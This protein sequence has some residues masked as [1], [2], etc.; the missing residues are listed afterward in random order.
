M[1]Q[2]I[3]DSVHIFSYKNRTESYEQDCFNMCLNLENFRNL[4]FYHIIIEKF[5]SIFMGNFCL[6]R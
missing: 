4:E 6:C 1:K 2:V 5:P 3:T